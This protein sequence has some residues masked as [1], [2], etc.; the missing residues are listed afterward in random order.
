M[1]EIEFAYCEHPR[2]IGASSWRRF[3]YS[4]SRRARVGISYEI[5]INTPRL[6]Q[7]VNQGVKS[8]R[9]TLRT[10]DS[11]ISNEFRRRRKASASADE[12]NSEFA[13]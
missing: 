3:V 7:I 1:E 8:S 10:I 12:N 2:G 6:V 9:M 13:A 4:E 5:I 11:E